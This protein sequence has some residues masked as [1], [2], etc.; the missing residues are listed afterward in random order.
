MAI[1]LM[2]RLMRQAR[3]L[4]LDLVT[5][6]SST[7]HAQQPLDIACFKS[8]R[9]VFWHCHNIWLLANKG[10]GARKEELAHW[11]SISFKRALTPTNI[12]AKFWSFGIRPLDDM[13]MDGKMSPSECWPFK[14][15]NKETLELMPISIEKIEAETLN[16]CTSD[17]QRCANHCFLEVDDEHTP[18]NCSPS[19]TLT[20]VEAMDESDDDIIPSTQCKDAQVILDHMG[21]TPP[22][23]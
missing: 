4:D 14:R 10:C 6:S 17:E 1:T 5:F 16:E 13:K 15:P 18:N 8:L 19:S 7:S 23:V 21:L 20:P 2:S 12:L 9:N 3:S 11:V 22:H